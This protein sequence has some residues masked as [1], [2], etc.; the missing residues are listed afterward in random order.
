MK[1]LEDEGLCTSCGKYLHYR[2]GEE[3]FSTIKKDLSNYN[4]YKDLFLFECPYCGHISTN[5]AGEEGI[6][7]DELRQSYE[8]SD[9]MGYAYLNRIDK[10]LYECHSQDICANWYEAY[11]YLLEKIGEYEKCCRALFKCIEL[12]KIMKQKYKISQAELGGEENN[13]SDYEKLYFLIDESIKKNQ[14]QF[15]LCYK[16][17][18]NKNVYLKLLHYENLVGQ[19]QDK[20]ACEELYEILKKYNLSVDLKKYISKIQNKN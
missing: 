18:S 15:N 4:K 13:D 14:K 5:I 11:A 10:I 3:N 17:V 12:K 19:H 2:Y 16:N 7:F 6:L 9:I 1:V 8:Y 20:E